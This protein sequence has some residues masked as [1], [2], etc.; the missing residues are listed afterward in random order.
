MCFIWVLPVRC[1]DY[2][3]SESNSSKMIQLTLNEYL[4]RTKQCSQYFPYVNSFIPH[5]K[6]CYEVGILTLWNRAQRS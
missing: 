3:S 6:N 4:L 5:D 1:L 2:K